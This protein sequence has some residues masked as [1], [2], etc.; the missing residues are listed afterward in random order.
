MYRLRVKH[1]LSARLRSKVRLYV[2]P[3]DLHRIRRQGSFTL[4]DSVINV[5]LTCKY[6][7]HFAHHSVRQKDQTCRPSML[8]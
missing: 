7:T 5:T 6:E 1:Y 4:K 8:R 2:P 3:P